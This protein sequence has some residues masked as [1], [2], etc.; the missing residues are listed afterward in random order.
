MITQSISAVLLAAGASSRFGA[1]DKLLA[2]IGGTPLVTRVAEQICQVEFAEVVAVVAPPPAGD[3]VAAALR[4]LPVRIVVNLDASRG[5]GTS[6][7]CGVAEVRDL[8]AGIMIIPGDM[9]GITTSLLRSLVALYQSTNGTCIVQPVT[10][11]GEQRNP[12]IW[13]PDLRSDL[14]S[15]DGA[16]GGKHLLAEHRSRIATYAASSRVFED[17]DT[18]DDLQRFRSEN[19]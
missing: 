6:I 1:A 14:S 10:T 12:V 11:S 19:S 18:Q 7:S 9:P 3:E 4:Q 8:T 17:I 5:M 16:A 15:L 2:H 13:P